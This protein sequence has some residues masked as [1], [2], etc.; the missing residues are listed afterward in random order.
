MIRRKEAD[1]SLSNHAAILSIAS[2][3]TSSTL[4]TVNSSTIFKQG[5][6]DASTRIL[7]SSPLKE[8]FLPS[9]LICLQYHFPRKSA[10]ESKAVSIKRSLMF[11]R[12][13]KKKLSRKNLQTKFRSC[14]SS[15]AFEQGSS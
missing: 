4:G 3:S 8:C 6:A 10:P 1:P 7:S 14:V 13:I 9:L 5:L 12:E 11:Q 2:C 15:F